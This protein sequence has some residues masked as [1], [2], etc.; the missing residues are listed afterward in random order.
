VKVIAEGLPEATDYFGIVR[1]LIDIPDC[2]V[3][4]HGAP[5]TMTYTQLSYNTINRERIHGR[6]FS[7]GVDETDIVMGSDSRLIRTILW[8]DEKYHPSAIAVVASAITA[9]IGLDVVGI[10][11]KVQS[12]VSARLIPF[13][14]GGFSGTYFSGI[15][16]GSRA[17]VDTF[18]VDRKVSRS[19][20]PTV[21]I[22]GPTGDVFNRASDYEEIRRILGLLGVQVNTVFPR[23]CSTSGIASIPSA[24]LNLVTRDLML[25]VATYIRDICG[26]EYL[27]GLPMGIR[28]T[29]QWIRDLSA[30]LDIPYPEMMVAR[31][32][33]SWAYALPELFGRVHPYE[34]F[35][36]VIAAPFEYAYGLSRIV[37]E[38]WGLQVS[39]VLLP[40]KP[41]SSSYS[42]AFATF[43]ISRVEVDLSDN[44]YRD[45]LRTEKPTLLFGNTYHLKMGKQVPI[46]IHAASPTPDL[47]TLFDGTP[48]AGFRGYAYL[49]QRLVNEAIAH[50]EVFRT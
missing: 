16:S 26:Q 31:E 21:N 43:G 3:V 23:G 2:I 11:H 42:D 28:G 47:I 30:H 4:E 10:C 38:D 24:D 41:R 6:I 9:V 17:L 33:A 15:E 32:V 44:R 22:L 49:T 35:S 1:T 46:R 7:S 37:T 34:Q 25:P 45:I 27:Y 13:P 29:I 20:S 8:I 12:Q 19:D 40:E 48:Y 5:G 18:L 50:P 14:S 39:S 36:A